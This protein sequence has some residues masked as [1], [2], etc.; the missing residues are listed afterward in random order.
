MRNLT[1]Y[2][3]W[4]H[5]ARPWYSSVLMSKGT[6]LVTQ[7]SCWRLS[8]VPQFV[9]SVVQQ[10]LDNFSCAVFD[11]LS[12]CHRPRR[13]TPIRRVRKMARVSV[14]DWPIGKGTAVGNSVL[15]SHAKIIRMKPPGLRAINS[16]APA[17]ACCIV[18]I[19]EFMRANDP[20]AS[21]RIYKH[22]RVPSYFG[23]SIVPI[24]RKALIAKM[25]TTDIV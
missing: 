6:G 22:A 14:R 25:V 13:L 2:L 19:I 16:R 3:H 10:A 18:V 1:Q 15:R 5:A 21:V 8:R 7:P 24:D 20:R 11:R 12:R 23:S 9:D 17:D 4:T